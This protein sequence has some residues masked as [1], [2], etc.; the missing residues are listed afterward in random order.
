MPIRGVIFGPFV[1]LLVHAF[2]P[3]VLILCV[4]GGAG[5]GAVGERVFHACRSPGDARGEGEAVRGVLACV[6]A[7]AGVWPGQWP[8]LWAP[9]PRGAVAARR[10]FGWGPGQ[11]G[12]AMSLAQGPQAGLA[13]A[14]THGPAWP[15]PARGHS[16][17][18]CRP[19]PASLLNVGTGHNE[20]S[21]PQDKPPTPNEGEA[22]E[23]DGGGCA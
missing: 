22:V 13:R 4:C 20:D 15:A 16:A 9:W 19:A 6:A 7:A 1:M 8:T 12:R 23:G 17:V 14:A 21:D 5:R 2:I 11:R 18:A 3:G 10:T